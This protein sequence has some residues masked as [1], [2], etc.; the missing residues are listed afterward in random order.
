MA[1]EKV[2]IA[3]SK[4]CQAFDALVK[5]DYGTCIAP[6]P[7][8]TPS[9]FGRHTDCF[10]GGGFTSSIPVLLTSAPEC[11][12]STAAFQFAANFQKANPNSV[13]VYLDIESAAAAIDEGNISN[14]ID[15]FRIDRSKFL[16]KPLVT[17]LEQVF[18]LIDALVGIKKKL[19]EHTGSEYRVLFIWDSLAS[20]AL[21]KELIV[22][23]PN[24][25]IGAKARM[26]TH[27]LAKN[28]A[29]FLMNKVT[30]MMIDQVRSNIQIQNPY[31]PRDEK[32]VGTFSNNFKSATNVNALQH[33][34]GQ[35]S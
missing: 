7:Y 16:Y 31:A 26:L 34:L 23:D 29:M 12:K 4:L 25:V 10:L 28:K 30:L 9:G 32:G 18:E 2:L 35:F 11:G 20:T 22:S 15:T 24:S 17:S 13:V 33:N 5:R 27:L 19:E 1:D 14:R 6:T 21:G 8:I 3:S